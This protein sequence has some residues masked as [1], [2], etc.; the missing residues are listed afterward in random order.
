[1]PRS[2]S[3]VFSLLWSGLAISL[4]SSGAAAQAQPWVRVPVPGAPTGITAFIDVNVVPM[5]TERVLPHQTVLVSGGWITAL[6]PVKQVQV[7][8]GAMRINGQSRYLLPGLA[9]MHSHVGYQ[10]GPCADLENNLFK[11]LAAGVTTIRNMDHMPTWCS[12]VVQFKARAEAGEVWSPRIY[13][14]GPWYPWTEDIRSR[15]QAQSILKRK[16]K[17]RPMPLTLEEIAGYVA[18]IKPESVAT[19]VAAYKAAGYD[20]IKPY[21]ETPEVFDSLLAV[22]RRLG[23][24]VAGH[25]PHSL[26]THPVPYSVSIEHALTGGMRSIEHLGGYYE[27][28]NSKHAV[29]S[30]GNDMSALQRQLDS[31]KP[32]IAALVGATKRAGAWNCPTL[33]AI[34]MFSTINNPL[35][36][37]LQDSGAGLLLGLH[38]FAPSEEL[39][40]FVRAG[41]TPYQ[42]LVTGTRNPAVYFGTLDSSGTIAVGKR[43]DLVL[44]QGNPLQDVGHTARP[45]G[46]MLGQRWLDRAEIDARLTDM[47][48]AGARG[49]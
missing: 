3:R 12:Q 1:M 48:A 17:G 36:K 49:P 18:S 4:A 33:Q 47:Q 40:E 32:T 44:L 29:A 30:K 13:T 24:P 41:L 20:F 8:A 15:V 9:D 27:H 21:I 35:V 11:L 22:G 14:S 10:D 38:L 31:A 34:S 42:A 39:Q 2:P 6:G 28:L 19:Y 7:P 46:V 16:R 37:A 45:V 25:V 26:R 43:A 5:D 23:L